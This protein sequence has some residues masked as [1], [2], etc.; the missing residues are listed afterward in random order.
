MG[1]IYKISST[2]YDKMTAGEGYWYRDVDWFKQ[3]GDNTVEGNGIAF[4]GKSFDQVIDSVKIIENYFVLRLKNSCYIYGILWDYGL[5]INNVTE[6]DLSI[7]FLK[8]GDEI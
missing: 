4:D 8:F 3:Q 7:N 2:K 6:N 5:N 1:F